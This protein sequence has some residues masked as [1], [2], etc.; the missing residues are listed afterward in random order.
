MKTTAEYYKT[1]ANEMR[2]ILDPLEMTEDQLIT[3]VSMLVSL[4]AS[5]ISRMGGRVPADKS[6]LVLGLVS[7]MHATAEVV[8]ANG[9]TMPE[10]KE[11]SV[12]ILPNQ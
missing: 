4:N 12:L 6:E 9:G 7:T 8:V 1:R 11:P 10:P 3:F 2:E 5:A